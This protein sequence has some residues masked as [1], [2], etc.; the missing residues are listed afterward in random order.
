MAVREKGVGGVDQ[1]TGSQVSISTIYRTLK[2]LGLTRKKLRHVS[3]RQ[4]DEAR[5]QFITE[6]AHLDASMMCLVR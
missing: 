6:M 5:E 2:R 1:V 3:I 4:C